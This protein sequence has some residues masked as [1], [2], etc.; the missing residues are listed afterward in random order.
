MPLANSVILT[1][2]LILFYGSI[3]VLVRAWRE[4]HY[5]GQVDEWLAH[6]I[7]RAPRIAAILIIL[8]VSLFSLDVFEMDAS[9][10]KILGAFLIHNIP[11]L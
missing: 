5:Q 3:Y 10:L 2:P 8:F 4:Y 11:S 7:H 6:I 1:I 9:P